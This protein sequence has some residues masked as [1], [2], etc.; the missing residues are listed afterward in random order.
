M[1]FYP[2]PQ[3]LPT[4]DFRAVLKAQI[5][6]GARE[7]GH[8]IAHDAGHKG[9]VRLVTRVSNISYE[10][11]Q[12]LNNILVTEQTGP[13]GKLVSKVY[14]EAFRKMKRTFYAGVIINSA[15]S[16][17][18]LLISDVVNRDIVNIEISP[19]KIIKNDLK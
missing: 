2:D 7:S 18:T 10:T 11:T 19:I 1:P 8:F 6:S 17:I 3:L 12:M 5:Q 9:G 4:K 16:A 15:I 13:K 14:V